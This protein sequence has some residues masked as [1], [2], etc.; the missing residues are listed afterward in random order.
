VTGKTRYGWV[1]L[2]AE[3]GKSGP[4]IKL[5][6]ILIKIGVKNLN[7]FL[8]LLAF[9][10]CSGCTIRTDL[11]VQNF[12]GRA[13][14]FKIVYYQ[15]I[16]LQKASEDIFQ[17]QSGIVNPKDVW[18]SRIN[19]ISE[20]LVTQDGT[21]TITFEIPSNSTCRIDVNSNTRYF[22]EIDYILIEDRKLTIKEFCDLTVGSARY[23]V[24]KIK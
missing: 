14:S 5:A 15:P 9:V 18:N 20:L 2:V 3:S 16:A 22:Q 17:W 10:I 7:K 13:I 19:N 11:F 12:I 1:F 24:F 23:R 4:I 21:N 6:V 8:L